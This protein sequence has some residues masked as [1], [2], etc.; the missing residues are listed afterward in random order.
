MTQ[1]LQLI[2]TD[3]AASDGSCDHMRRILRSQVWPHRLA[4]GFPEDDV[5]TAGKTG[6]LITWRNEM[7]TVGYPDG[8]QF[9]VAVYTRSRRARIKNPAADAVIGSAARTAVDALRAV[10]R[11]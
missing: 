1:L 9:A 8:S 7:G 11:R 10:Q 3:Q 6:T 5:V 2:L 4:S